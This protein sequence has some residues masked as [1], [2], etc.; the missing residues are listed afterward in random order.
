MSPSGN[1]RG[2]LVRVC[3]G[4]VTCPIFHTFSST[5]TGLRSAYQKYFRPQRLSYKRQLNYFHP[6]AVG[7]S[8]LFPHKFLKGF[9]QAEGAEMVNCWVKI[10]FLYWPHVFQ[11]VWSRFPSHFP[12][13]HIH[14]PSHFYYCHSLLSYNFYFCHIRSYFSFLLY[15]HLYIQLVMFTPLKVISFGSRWYSLTSWK[16]RICLWMNLNNYRRLV[17]WTILPQ[18]DLNVFPMLCMC[19]CTPIGRCF[20]HTHKF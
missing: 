7:V 19:V 17:H 8:R 4:W 13:F 14:F 2:R 9:S 3:D 12:F 11:F 15:V 18:I 6:S 5:P 1:G 10:I 20:C 16:S